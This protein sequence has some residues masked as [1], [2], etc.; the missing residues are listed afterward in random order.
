[1]ARDARR[2]QPAIRTRARTAPPR[3]I[4]PTQWRPSRD[5]RA[6]CNH[7]ITGSDPRNRDFGVRPQDSQRTARAPPTRCP[8]AA[9][10][11]P[12]TDRRDTARPLAADRRRPARA[13][14]REVRAPEPGREREGPASRWRSS[15]M[16]SGAAHS[17][18]A[19]TIV[20]AT[21]GNTGVGLA[22]IA[23]VRGYRLVCVMPEKMSVDKRH[24]LAQLG[25]QLVITDNAPPPTRATSR[26]WRA[27][28]PRS[29]AG[30]SPTSSRTPRTPTSTRRPPA[31]RS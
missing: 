4:S 26:T 29:T 17:I 10:R 14:A 21:A 11:H 30:S 31:P 13:A 27:R 15:T 16:P 20:E 24:A 12:R 22:L 1:M 28:S 6:L 25:A 9:A 7:F 2:S 8:G 19:A 5:L 3:H 23:A 18:A